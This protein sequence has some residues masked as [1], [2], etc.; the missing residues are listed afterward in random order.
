M[1]P[2]EHAF[3]LSSY[4]YI[5]DLVAPDQT[6]REWKAVVPDCVYLLVIIRHCP[7]FVSERSLCSFLFSSDYS[8]G[9]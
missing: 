8:A 6:S 9:L 1:I 2:L 7:S 4:L 5:K 3:Q